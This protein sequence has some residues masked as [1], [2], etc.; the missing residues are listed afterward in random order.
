M[1]KAKPEKLPL[2]IVDDRQLAKMIYD[3]VP[4][5]SEIEYFNGDLESYVVE[6]IVFTDGDVCLN[7]KNEDVDGVPYMYPSQ[8]KDM[9]KCLIEC[10]VQP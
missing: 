4:D 9:M 5:V 1:I 7:S 6:L 8:V 2:F 10:G 3:L